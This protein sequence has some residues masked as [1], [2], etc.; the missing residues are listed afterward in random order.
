M[1]YVCL[2][3][4]LLA[5]PLSADAQQKRS[6]DR[7]S[8]HARSEQQKSDQR[9]SA[10]PKSSLPWWE[11]QGPP[12]WEQKKTPAWEL[13]QIPGWE[14]GNVARA[15]LDQ[16]RYQS[17][18]LRNQRGYVNQRVRQ[19]Q[20]T[21]VYVLPTYQY[22]PQAPFVVTPPAPTSAI[23]VSPEPPA[24]P[25]GALR[26]EVEPRELLQIF[27]DGSFVGTPAD[28]GDE[29]ELTPGT[30]RIELRAR[31]HRSMTFTADILDGRSITYRGALEQIVVAPA[32]PPSPA[33]P[34]SPQASRAPE[35]PQ[36]PQAPKVMYVIPGCYLGNVSPTTMTLPQGCDLSKLTTIKP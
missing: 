21:V 12:A 2:A 10:Q 18:Q 35:A 27:V 32:T 20:P 22:F 7:R 1:K 24:P 17:Q 26:I 34:R 16:Q 33:A 4:M 14:K 36:A 6:D 15:M 29:L 5:L 23:T 9:E 8:D 25:M 19:Y 13:N 28:H 11:R 3:V 30:H 31:G